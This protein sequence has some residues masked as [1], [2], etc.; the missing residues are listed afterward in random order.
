VSLSIVFK[1]S[2][3]SPKINLFTSI[4]APERLIRA[5]IQAI[6]VSV[7][8]FRY[9]ALA[10]LQPTPRRLGEAAASTKLHAGDKPSIF[11]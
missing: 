11:H 6:S 3:L 1:I 8:N 7:L 10:A 2:K 5:A 4:T 9:C